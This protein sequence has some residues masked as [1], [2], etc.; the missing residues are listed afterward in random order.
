[1][2]LMLQH[3]SPLDFVDCNPLE[4]AQ[5]RREAAQA[6]RGTTQMSRGLSMETDPTL[7][8]MN[9]NE[10]ANNPLRLAEATQPALQPTSDPSPQIRDEYSVSPRKWEICPRDQWRVAILN[11]PR[12]TVRP[13][14]LIQTRRRGLLNDVIYKYA[15]E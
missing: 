12:V 2:V 6:R 9:L 7:A 15:G 13:E 1:M 10:P 5:A 4:V 11:L 8:W 3:S 14:D